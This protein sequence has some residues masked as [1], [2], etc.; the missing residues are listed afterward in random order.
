MPPRILYFKDIPEYV[1]QKHGLTVGPL[2]AYNWIRYKGVPAP[3]RGRK[4]C[5]C[6]L[7]FTRMSLTRE[8]GTLVTTARDVDEFLKLKGMI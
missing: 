7:N 8:G 5:G 6:T 4:W 2:A 1:L 3:R